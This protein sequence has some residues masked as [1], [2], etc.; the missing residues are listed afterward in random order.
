MLQPDLIDCECEHISFQ[1]VAGTNR[2]T[3]MYVM[4]RYD[5]IVERNKNIRLLQYRHCYITGTL[6]T[7]N[8][9]ILLLCI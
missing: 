1:N 5:S 7:F 4:Y 9:N 2:K 6:A 3:C 8:T